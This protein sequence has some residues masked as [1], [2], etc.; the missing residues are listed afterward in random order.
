MN[1]ELEQD[2]IEFAGEIT[3]SIFLRLQYLHLGWR[4]FAGFLFIPIV[5]AV[6]LTGKPDLQLTVITIITAIVVAAIMLGG[7]E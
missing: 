2:E 3:S 7:N 1:T 5:L 6:T 4:R